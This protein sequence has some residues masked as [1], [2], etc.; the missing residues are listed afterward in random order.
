MIR[1]VESSHRHAL[2]KLRA[3]WNNRRPVLL[4]SHPASPTIWHASRNGF[5][6]HRSQHAEIETRRSAHLGAI[7]GG[8][9]GRAARA[10]EPA[11]HGGRQRAV[12]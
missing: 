11:Y 10:A 6:L 7:A 1:Q 9:P 8:A 5:A 4:D 12:K 2:S 3:V